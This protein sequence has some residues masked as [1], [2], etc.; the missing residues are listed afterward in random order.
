MRRTG[1]VSGRKATDYGEETVTMRGKKTLNLMQYQKQNYKKI[2]CILMFFDYVIELSD[3]GAGKSI[4][5]LLYSLD[6]NYPMVIFTPAAIICSEWVAKVN[7]YNK[8]EDPKVNIPYSTLTSVNSPYLRILSSSGDKSSSKKEKGETLNVY[9]LTDKMKDLIDEGCLL[10]LDEAHSLKNYKSNRSRACLEICKY[11]YLSNSKK[12]VGERRTKIWFLSASLLDKKVLTLSFLRFLDLAIHPK[13][14]TS[15]SER[16]VDDPQRRLSRG[17]LSD[18]MNTIKGFC[19]KFDIDQIELEENGSVITSRRGTPILP[20]KED[21]ISVSADMISY[22]DGLY[23]A[24]QFNPSLANKER[25][26]GVESPQWKDWSQ[27]NKRRGMRTGRS[28][29]SRE[30]LFYPPMTIKDQTNIPLGSDGNFYDK[31]NLEDLNNFLFA[32]FANVICASV[33]TRM[34]NYAVRKFVY[35]GIYHLNPFGLEPKY[36]K[37]IGFG[38]IVD[39]FDKA[40]KRE[41]EAAARAETRT[42]TG[43]KAIS[44]YMDNIQKV[45]EYSLHAIMR[46]IVRDLRRSRHCKIIIFFHYHDCMDLLESIITGDMTK[47]N[48][49][50][51]K[52]ERSRKI[53]KGDS[54]GEHTFFKDGMMGYLNNGFAGNAKAERHHLYL[55]KMAPHY[56]RIDGLTPIKDRNRIISDLQADNGKVR[57]FFVSAKTGKEGVN[58]HNVHGKWYRTI[59]AVPSDDVIADY[60]Q[61][62]RVFRAVPPAILARK[63]YA[64]SQGKLI[65]GMDNKRRT[66]GPVLERQIAKTAVLSEII[67]GKEAFDP[68]ADEETIAFNKVA[69]RYPG[70]WDV[71]IDKIGDL[72]D[73]YMNSD[74]YPMTNSADRNQGVIT[75]NLSNILDDAAKADKDPTYL[76]QMLDD[77][78]ILPVPAVKLTDY[79]E[80]IEDE[81]AGFDSEIQTEELADMEM[82][83]FDMQLLRREKMNKYET[84]KYLAERWNISLESSSEEEEASSRSSRSSGENSYRNRSDVSGE[85]SSSSFSRRVNRPRGK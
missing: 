14:Y 73:C 11:V 38:S 24:N 3:T 21:V 8:L 22:V 62:G 41:T 57:I 27:E 65:I 67:T 25:K 74:S 60:Q 19:I 51:T 63:D 58:F 84:I 64:L 29:A 9:E 36:D 39:A 82:E 50:M 77:R 66:F 32:L 46:Q 15:T 43:K 10:V 56:R 78:K 48:K 18:V 47:V 70:N 83:L 55:R 13:F 35:R 54:T 6:F 16:V 7:T 4:M 69:T 1:G 49:M 76:D 71:Y 59:Y 85:A 68:D 12:G 33:G 44:V 40:L 31:F 81:R 45:E 79:V 23:E 75:I 42:M 30:A 53:Q 72:R 2:V 52:D 61:N 37:S 17:Y 80:G 5:V 28:T 20:E 34:I 26:V